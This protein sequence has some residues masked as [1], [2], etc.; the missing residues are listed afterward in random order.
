MDR[1]LPWE[2]ESSDVENFSTFIKAVVL[3]S[4]GEHVLVK[5]SLYKV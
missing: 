5:D 3:E 4:Y 2:E 1:I